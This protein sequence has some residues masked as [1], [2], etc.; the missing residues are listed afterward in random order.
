MPIVTIETL[1]DSLYSDD[2]AMPTVQ[3]ADAS[4]S[5]GDYWLVPVSPE[6]VFPQTEEPGQGALVKITEDMNVR[7]GPGID[8]ELVGELDI[9]TRVEVVGKSWDGYWLKINY[10]RLGADETWIFSELTDFDPRRFI[11]L[12]ILG[13]REEVLTDPHLWHCAACFTCQD[14][15]P[16]NVGFADIMFVLKSLAA[17]AGNC[18]P[19]LGAQPEL[20]RRHGRLYEITEFENKK[21][22]ELGLPPLYE[23]PADFVVLLE[24]INFKED[25][26]E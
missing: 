20:L 5:L 24:Q 12:I 19:G 2:D 17:A 3:F 11:R 18:P 7:A 6:L 26:A 25:E 22:A 1:S 21:R 13:M 10:P 23:H 4:Q 14:T 15:C 8:Y 16:E 9:H